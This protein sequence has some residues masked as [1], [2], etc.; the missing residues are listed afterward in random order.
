MNVQKRVTNIA[1][2]TVSVVVLITILFLVSCSGYNDD[3]G[4]GDAPIESRD[5]S[6]AIIVNFPDKFHN[7][8][9]KCM[10]KNG[11]YTHTRSGSPPIIIANDPECQ[12]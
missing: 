3:R 12:Q 10:G 11:I 6:S 4:R 9:F 1:W 7:V 8:A 5:D 2:G